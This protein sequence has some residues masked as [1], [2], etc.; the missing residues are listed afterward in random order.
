M[1]T[2]W[3]KGGWDGGVS[4]TYVCA[5]VHVIGVYSTCIEIS[6]FWEHNTYKGIHGD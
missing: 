5:C 1:F 3:I 4:V 2:I 6:E